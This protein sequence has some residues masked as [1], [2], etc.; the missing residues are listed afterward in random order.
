MLKRPLELAM[1]FVWLLE[2]T[3]VMFKG[4]LTASVSPD[5]IKPENSSA[6]S[7]LGL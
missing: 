7:R 3:A 5:S 2:F 4:Y 1:K 6:D